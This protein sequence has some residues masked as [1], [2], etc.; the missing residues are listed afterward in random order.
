MNVAERE[1]QNRALIFSRELDPVWAQID[2]M[3][4]EDVADEM[5]EILR[6][7]ELPVA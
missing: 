5:I 4:G 1:A 3:V 6:A 7:Q 2:R